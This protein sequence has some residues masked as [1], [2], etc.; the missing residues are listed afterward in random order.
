MRESKINYNPFLSVKDNA[1]KNGV[2]EAS[3]RY[4]IRVNNLDRR[5]DGK[6]KIVDDC[7]KYLKKHPEATKTELQHKTGHSLSTIRQYWEYITT[8]KE[9][10]NFDSKKTQ[11]RLLRQGNNY[12]ATHPSV[13]QDLLNVEQFDNKIL[14]PFCGGGTMAEV[15]KANGYQVEAYDIADRKYGNQGD[16]FKV[17]FPKEEYDIITNP[18]YDDS[19]ITIVNRC[20]DLCKN[21]V[22]LLLPMLYLSGK[23]RYSEIYKVNPPARIYVYTQ[24]INIAKN[25]DFIKYSDSGANMT[26]YAWF[27]WEKGHTGTTELRWIHNDRTA[28]S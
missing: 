28:W 21:K 19:L 12:Y 8:E 17:A 25:G 13:T 23:A 9:L 7:R 5:Y 15:I 1:I 20:L 24:R 26:I 2:T 16:F 14:E 4:Y 3:I 10:N 18:P 6:L 11:V 22:A 27:I